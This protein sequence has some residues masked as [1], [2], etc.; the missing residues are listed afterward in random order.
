M[1]DLLCLGLLYLSCSSGMG[2]ASLSGQNFLG[3]S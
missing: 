1:D 2:P 3:Y